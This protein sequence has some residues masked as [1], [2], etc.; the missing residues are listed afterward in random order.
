MFEFYRL[1]KIPPLFFPE[2]K[3]ISLFPLLRYAVRN[4]GTFESVKCSYVHR[5][6]LERIEDCVSIYLSNHSWLFYHFACD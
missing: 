5:H 1:T 6:Y 3:E 2:L 4:L